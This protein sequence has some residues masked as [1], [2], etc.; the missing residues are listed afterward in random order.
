MSIPDSTLKIQTLGHFE[1]SLSGKAMATEWPDETT[2]LLFC[3]L[4]SPLDLHFSWDRICR[5]LLGVPATRTSRR[6]LEESFIRPLNAFLNSELGFT[7]L[8]SGPENIR[9]DQQY[10]RV[11]AH[12]FYSI[13][14][15]GLR[16]VSRGDPAAAQAKFSAAA[17]LYTGLYLPDMTGK[18]I[19]NTRNELDALYRTAIID[20]MPLTRNFGG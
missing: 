13:A 3:S 5:A 12:E 15:E 7:L 2:K 1:I 20:A 17:A 14:L 8:V 9:L 18:I 19:T 11:D 16:L 6:L 4:L 10:I